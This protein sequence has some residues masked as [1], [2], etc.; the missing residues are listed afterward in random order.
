MF[1]TPQHGKGSKPRITDYKRYG[2]NHDEI[3]KKK[4]KD[5]TAEPKPAEVTEKKET[6]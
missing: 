3:Y 5:A 2:D 1:S 6:P 4:A